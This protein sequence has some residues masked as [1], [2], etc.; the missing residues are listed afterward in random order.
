MSDAVVSADAVF[1][2]WLADLGWMD[3]RSLDARISEMEE[4]ALSLESDRVQ[5]EHICQD[6]NGLITRF[7]HETVSRMHACIETSAGRSIAASRPSSRISNTSAPR[8]ALSLG[9]RS[10]SV[11]PRVSFARESRDG[12]TI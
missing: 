2:F 5:F 12:E 11:T 8:A 3:E 4:I 6:P 1:R 7:N 10:Q 9:S